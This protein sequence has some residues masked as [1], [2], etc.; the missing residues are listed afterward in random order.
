MKIF[1]E[2]VNYSQGASGSYQ[3][4]CSQS[5]GSYGLPYRKSRKLAESYDGTAEKFLADLD[6]MKS[7]VITGSPDSIE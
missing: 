4:D 1:L 3:C 2:T 5:P 7:Y 6:A